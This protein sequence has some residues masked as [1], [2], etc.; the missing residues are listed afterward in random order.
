MNEKLEMLKKELTETINKIEN[1]K[2]MKIIGLNVKHK[3]YGIGKVKVQQENKIEVEFG[4]NQIKKFVIPDVFINK[5]L[6]IDDITIKEKI[7]ELKDLYMQ[8]NEIEEKAKAEINEINKIE[9]ER[10]LEKNKY[11]Y[12][13]NDTSII[14]KEVQYY[15]DKGYIETSDNAIFKTIRDVSDLFNKNYKGLQKCCVV[16]G[17]EKEYFWCPKLEIDMQDKIDLEKLPYLNTISQD[18][19]FIYESNKKDPIGFVKDMLLYRSND[20]RITFPKY[21]KL[22][23]YVFEGIYE[24]DIEATKETLILTHPKVV[25]KRMHNKVELTKYF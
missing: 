11:R 15:I 25:W 12:E 19:E 7:S 13:K 5:F 17:F 9:A 21:N 10:N 4:N 16:T 3:S 24:M 23:G 14:Y 8:K 18:K 2:N 6:E 22:N 1:T 20:L